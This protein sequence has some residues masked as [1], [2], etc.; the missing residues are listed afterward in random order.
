MEATFLSVLD[1]SDVFH[2]HAPISNL[3]HLDAVYHSVLI[4]MAITLITNNPYGAHRVL[5]QKVGWHSLS[6][7]LFSALLS[8]FIY[9][10]IDIYF[11]K[12]LPY[13]SSLL[14]PRYTY[15]GHSQDW[16][17]LYCMYAVVY[18]NVYLNLC[19]FLLFYYYISM[20]LPLSLL[21][22]FILWF[23]TQFSLVNDISV[24][25]WLSSLPA[26]WLA[27]CLA[28]NIHV[29]WIAAGVLSLHVCLSV[30]SYIGVDA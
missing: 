28:E 15:N 16:L 1:Y 11:K 8:T 26:H 20:P 10:S 19:H 2:R 6:A 18:M 22:I 9:S 23:C 24:S 30:S 21:F 25:V 3:K 29:A 12:L 17:T 5:Y 14:C 7:L 27:G 13:L 4:T